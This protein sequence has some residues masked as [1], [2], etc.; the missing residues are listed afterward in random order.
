MTLSF[1]EY[2][3]WTNSL[4]LENGNIIEFKVLT[5]LIIFESYENLVI[6]L[7]H[8]K[9]GTS[10]ISNDLTKLIALYIYLMVLP[11]LY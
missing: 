2:T 6:I 10:L 5:T 8:F 4:L 1:I 11:T 3:A 7:R 9:L